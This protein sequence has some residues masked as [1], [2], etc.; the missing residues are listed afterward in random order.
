[1]EQ[2]LV[3]VI[4]PAYNSG[5]F[6]AAAIQ[7]VLDQSYPHFELLILDDGS[8]DHT[9]DLARSFTDNRINIYLS[10]SNLGQAHQMNRGFELASGE[11]ICMMHADDIM[12]PVRL[13]RQLRFLNDHLPVGVCGTNIELIGEKNGPYNFPEGNANCRNRLLDTV[14]FAHSSVMFRSAIVKNSFLYK[15]HYVPAEDYELWTRLAMVTD[16]DNVQECLLEYRVHPNQAGTL[17]KNIEESRL[18]E[19]RLHMLSRF[20]KTDLATAK[21][22]YDTFYHYQSMLPGHVL[23]GVGL[24]WT[25]HLRS[26][27]F[28]TTFLQG[29]LKHIIYTVLKN[30]S[31][32]EKVT[33]FFRHKSLIRPA[34]MLSMLRS[35]T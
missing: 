9:V 5:F 15:Q 13:E 34:F 20:F 22:M 16:F 35:F 21:M 32:R 11:F 18:A 26:P 27:F 1:M 29:R 25:C 17:K 7:S 6:I 24:I 23:R 33:L 10:P 12:K 4:L 19:L 8:T 28:T 31:P 30:V 3:T 14:P 2:P